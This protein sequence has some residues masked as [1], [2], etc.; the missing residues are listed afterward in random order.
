[1]RSFYTLYPELRGMI[2][3]AVLTKLV[4]EAILGPNRS[5]AGTNSQ[6]AESISKTSRRKLELGEADMN[7][8]S[9]DCGI[10]G[11]VEPESRMAE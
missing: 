1:M 5:P 8:V 9:T 10:R 11:P 6:N 3:S 7:S 4:T 2:R